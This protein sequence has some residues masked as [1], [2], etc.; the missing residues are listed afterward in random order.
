LEDEEGQEIRMGGSVAATEGISF[1]CA[2]AGSKSS[3]SQT[4][5]DITLRYGGKSY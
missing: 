2:I 4:P 1:A 5:N 3:S